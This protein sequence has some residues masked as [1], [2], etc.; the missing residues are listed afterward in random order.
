[1]IIKVQKIAS[2][3]EGVVVDEVH[4]IDKIEV[5]LSE[6]IRELR[7]RDAMRDLK[8]NKLT[9]TTLAPERKREYPKRVNGG[10]QLIPPDR[11]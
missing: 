3:I 10:V 4:D 8:F 2:P 6:T 5:M 11:C 7:T 9:E 1:M